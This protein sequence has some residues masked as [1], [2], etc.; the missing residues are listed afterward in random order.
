MAAPPHRFRAHQRTAAPAPLLEQMLEARTKRRGQRVVRIVV[1][2]LVRPE[3]VEVRGH[4]WRLSATASE[5]RD[6]LI[7]DT[8]AG[9]SLRQC[10][11]IELRVGSGHR[12]LPDVDEELDGRLPQQLDE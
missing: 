1:E 3:A 9:Q 4:P 5:C 11:L 10:L 12:N 7:V 6:G 8:E 2:A